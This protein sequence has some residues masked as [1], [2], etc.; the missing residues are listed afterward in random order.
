[1]QTTVTYTKEHVE[2]LVKLAFVRGQEFA[3]AQMLKQAD[4]RVAL[5]IGDRHEYKSEVSEDNTAVERE[6][7][8]IASAC[9]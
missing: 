5:A 3:T 9:A 1:M 4:E 7:G 8:C 6:T 2:L